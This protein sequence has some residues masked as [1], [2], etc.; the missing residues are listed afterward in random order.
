MAHYGSLITGRFVIP[1]FHKGS[2][3]VHLLFHNPGKQVENPNV[4]NRQDV[5]HCHQVIMYVPCSLMKLRC[6]KN[7][8]RH[9]N[10]ENAN[11]VLQHF[12]L[13]TWYST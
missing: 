5:T 3:E 9:L 2:L 12:C 4:L 13:C 8:K 7:G 11:V 6:L 10:A 1:Y